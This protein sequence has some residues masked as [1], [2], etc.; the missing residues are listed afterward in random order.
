M[1]EIVISLS[2]MFVTAGVLLLVANHFGLSPVPFYIIAGVLVSPFIAQQNLI[3][4][5][6]WGIAFLV[7]V[8]GIR[9]DI[10]DIQ[11]V[12]RDAEVAAFVQ[13]AVVGAT[14]FVIGYGFSTG[15]GFAYPLRNAIYFSAAATLSSTIVGS[16]ALERDILDNLVHGRLASSIHFFDDIVAIGVILILSAEL[17]T[18]PQQI[19]SK[20]GYG[21]LFLLTGLVLYRHGYPL[22]IRAAEG[23]DELVLMGSISILIAFIAAAEAVGISIVVGAFAAG[24]AIRS[25]GAEAIG[26]QNGIESIR[27]FFVAIF[28]VTVGALVQL[29]TVEV[30]LIAG[31]LLLLVLLVNP[32]ILM[33][34]FIYEGYDT[35]TSTLASLSL[36]QVSELTL[37]IAIQ[38]LL[39]GTISDQLFDAIILSAAV[40]MILTVMTKRHEEVI[41]EVFVRKLFGSWQAQH[42][43]KHSHVEESLSDHVVV[44]GYGRQGRH[45]VQ[46]L[47]ELGEP[48]VVVENDPILRDDLR[49]DCENYLFG[50]VMAAYTM[51]WANL[52]DARLVI[53]TVD[54]EPVSE[55]LLTH[56]TDADVI[57]RAE[58]SREARKLLDAGAM[59][60]NVPSVLASDQ[61]IENVG[62]VIKDETVILSLK[63]EHL[64]TLKQFEEHG[65]ATRFNRG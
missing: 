54:H 29:P 44:V 10:G 40:T 26:V 27:D 31:T 45:I 58:S 13:I 65:F 2:I 6:Q 52:S 22:L 64:D 39:L 41:Y 46:T 5:A 12:F 7:F 35:R 3:E 43:N 62:R 11:A 24:L 28:F 57:L 55:A 15:F 4:L 37:I 49:T 33:V 59:Y 19:T 25:E 1:T 51:D 48:Y 50:D 14:A 61:L 17:L 38:A 56:R 47:D 18:D 8:F 63:R 32:L 34:T 36:N 30:V 53:S 20:I 23:F 9:T 21:V 16:G 42:L 60:V